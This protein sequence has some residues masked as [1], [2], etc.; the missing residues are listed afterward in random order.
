M[1]VAMSTACIA[2]DKGCPRM[3]VDVA[4]LYR[5]LEANGWVLVDDVAEANLVLAACCAVHEGAEKSGFE[6]LEHLDARRK[7]GSRLIAMGCLAGICHEQLAAAHPGVAAVPPARSGHLDELIGA[8]VKLADVPDVQD[9]APYEARARRSMGYA[10][11]GSA[12]R[13]A[14]QVLRSTG[15]RRAQGDASA[16]SG[17]GS[18]AGVCSLRVAWGCAN[19]CTYCAIRIAAGPLRSKPLATVLAEFDAGLAAGFERFE[20]IAGDVGCWGQDLGAGIVDLLAGLFERSGEYRFVIDDLNPR[21]LLRH[22]EELIPMLAANADRIAEIT[23]PVQSG[24]EQ[25]LAAM[26][27]GYSAKELVEGLTRL[28]AAAEGLRL[29]THVLVGFPGEGETEFDETR[30]LLGAVRFDRVD[31]YP[32]ADRPHAPSGSLPGKVAQDVIEARCA[33]LVAEFPTVVADYN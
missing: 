5:Y 20:V 2:L 21:W 29:V 26:R 15:L 27:R 10:M 1:D 4:L 11:D 17:N 24:S 13:L 14:R 7:K 8:R 12:R 22:Q 31:A 30:T 18:E 33:R 19:E 28:R 25:I 3:T 23:V 6:C 16:P 32:Y 9:R